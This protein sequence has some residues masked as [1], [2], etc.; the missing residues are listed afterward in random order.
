MSAELLAWAV[1]TGRFTFHKDT[2][3]DEAQLEKK[4]KAVQ[5]G[6]ADGVPIAWGGVAGVLLVVAVF[7]GRRRR[8][9]WCA[10]VDVC[11]SAC[12]RVCVSACLHIRAR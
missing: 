11:R 1:S 10:P 2:C 5:V 12:V 3:C 7:W 6:G 9:C 4:I 8:W